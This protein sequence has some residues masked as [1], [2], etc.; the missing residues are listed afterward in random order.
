LY[1]F[2]ADYIAPRDP[3]PKGQESL[4]QGLL[5]VSRK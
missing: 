2:S 4:A 1:V 5:W 3:A